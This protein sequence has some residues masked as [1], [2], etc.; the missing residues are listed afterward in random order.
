M[1][2]SFYRRSLPVG[3]LPVKDSRSSNLKLIREKILNAALGLTLVLGLIALIIAVPARIQNNQNW[4]VVI[5]TLAFSWI[6]IMAI[7]RSLS[8]NLRSLSLIAVILLLGISTLV[9]DGL[10]GNGRIFLLVVPIITSIF[11]GS[12][13]G[14]FSLIV[15]WILFGGVGYL[16]SD[17]VSI[18]PLS[19]VSEDMNTLWI[20]ALSAFILISGTLYGVMRSMLAGFF[21]VLDSEKELRVDLDAERSQLERRVQIHTQHLESQ[22][23]QT[24]IAAEIL[25]SL[26]SILDPEE[27]LVQFVDLIKEK[28]VLY[29]VGIFELTDSGN[30]LDLKYGSGDEG[31]RM[32]TEKFS[33]LVN[34]D[35]LVGWAIL[36]RKSRFATDVGQDA[37]QFN[38]PLL[39]ETHSELVIPLISSTP[40]NPVVHRSHVEIPHSYTGVLSIQSKKVMAFS[41][42]DVTIFQII[43]KGLITAI[44]NAKLYQEMNNSYVEMENLNRQ[45]LRDS[46]FKISS[47][48][49][50]L[51]HTAEDELPQEYPAGEESACII[52]LVLKD[53]VIG[54]LSLE[55]DINSPQPF[56][57]V[58]ED[59][60][61]VD[62]VLTETALALENVRLLEET[63]L[64]ANNEHLLSELSRHAQSSTDLESILQLAV[65]ELGRSLGASEAL[66]ELQVPKVNPSKL[67]NED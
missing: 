5:F 42:E 27:I 9:L 30:R 49:G 31:F 32:V 28:F 59:R 26:N 14:F 60:K 43:A 21:G 66:I 4:L 22:L 52:P 56:D 50:V 45:Y 29:F 16:Y 18:L 33:I 17:H 8:F 35:L 34:T 40:M 23:I 55:G 48:H 51:A 61:F 6:L 37:V 64:R 62:A 7:S 46:W 58:D 11:L 39:P 3:P 19:K 12:R 63:Q 2:R 25:I 54:L 10:E 57:L 44:E 36:N 47:A 15:V 38:Y 24:Q 53:Q 41:Q 65:K 13:S 1:K 20:V 67:N